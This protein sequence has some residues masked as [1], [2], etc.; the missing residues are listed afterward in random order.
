[1]H[2]P[3][4]FGQIVRLG[5]AYGRGQAVPHR[6]RM[7]VHQQRLAP[8]GPHRGDT[9]PGEPLRDVQLP[10][11]AVE[12]FGVPAHLDHQLTGGEDRVLAQGEEFGLPGRPRQH[13]RR[14]QYVPRPRLVHPSP[15]SPRAVPARSPRPRVP[16]SP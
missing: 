2:H 16:A 13:A 8:G 7:T 9:G 12:E 14:G 10:P 3:E 6:H 4:Q 11:G 15:P 1:M 5:G